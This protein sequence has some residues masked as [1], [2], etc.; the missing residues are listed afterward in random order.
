[1]FRTVAGQRR[2][3]A[4]IAI[5]AFLVVAGPAAASRPDASTYDPTEVTETGATLNGYA[6]GGGTPVTYH[7]EYGAT[8]AYGKQ[9]PEAEPTTSGA[10][11]P[12]VNASQRVEPG[13]STLHFRIVVTN[14]AGEKGL[15]QDIEWKTPGAP[16][17]GPARPGR[18]RPSGPRLGHDRLES[19]QVEPGLPGESR[20]PRR[21]GLQENQTVRLKGESDEN[22]F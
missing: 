12:N 1:M 20:R 9:T 6:G 13:G 14:E 2:I 16:P 10:D 7:F 21:A 15:G 8:K 19:E 4:L 17:P 22:D 11:D 5:A 3:S 18:R